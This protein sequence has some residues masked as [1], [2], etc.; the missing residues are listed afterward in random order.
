M[1]FDGERGKEA[2]IVEHRTNAFGALV[3]TGPDFCGAANWCQV[4][5]GMCS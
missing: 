2:A 3:G 4:L 5:W 1:Y